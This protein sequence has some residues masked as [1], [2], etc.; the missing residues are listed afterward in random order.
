M[1]AIAGSLF[2]GV[3]EFKAFNENKARHDCAIAFHLE[4][5]DQNTATT[6]VKPIDD[7]YAQCLAE[8]GL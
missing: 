4:F 6:V 8:K 7:L 1:L 3:T 5:Y 2:L